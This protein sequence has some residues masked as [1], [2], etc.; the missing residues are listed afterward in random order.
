MAEYLNRSNTLLSEQVTLLQEA[1]S[2]WVKDADVSQKRLEH[3]EK[4]RKHLNLPRF[5]LEG[6]T[7]HG[8][9]VSLKF[10]NK[11][12]LC[13]L[14]N[15]TSLQNRGL[16]ILTKEN[17]TIDTSAL[18]EVKV[19]FDSSIH[20]SELSFNVN[21]SDIENNHYSQYVHGNPMKPKIDL[22]VEKLDIA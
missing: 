22:P 12:K 16:S 7:G 15:V 20:S 6:C 8:T 3:E 5:E 4:G 9:E 1:R 14:E 2:T 19:T 21:F 17:S 18:I 10:I 13:T 11:G